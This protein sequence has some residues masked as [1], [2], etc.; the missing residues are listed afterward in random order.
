[1]IIYDFNIERIAVFPQ[2]ANS[3]LIVDSDAIVTLPVTR[4]RL[5]PVSRNSRDVLQFLGIV[6]HPE[7]PPRDDFDAA[8]L[9]TMEAIEQFRGFL[10]AEGPDQ[11]GSISRRTLT[12]NVKVPPS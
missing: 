12:R 8:K 10:A 6:E 5:K 4:Q 9:A 7:L 1:M 2:K 11:Y 3:P